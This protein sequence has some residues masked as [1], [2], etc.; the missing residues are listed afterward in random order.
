[1]SIL[2]LVKV[3][4]ILLLTLSGILSCAVAPEKPKISINTTEWEL[5][6]EN[7]NQF[8]TN[9]PKYYDSYVYC[10]MTNG[11]NLN[12]AGTIVEAQVNKKSGSVD[13]GYGIVFNAKDKDNF[14]KFII[15]TDGWCYLSV[16]VNSYYTTIK[17]WSTSPFINQGYNTINTLKVSNNL[18]AGTYNYYIN[19][20]LVYTTSMTNYTGI[21]GPGFYLDI[22]EQDDEKF[23]DTPVDVR[24]KMLDGIALP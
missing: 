1:M 22:G 21:G 6:S 4:P 13:Y 15:T 18:S 5:D 2:K 8:K 20:S 3:L 24:F 12:T 14:Y 10:Y 17:S 7:F 19:N 23:P 16:C 9:D 11:K